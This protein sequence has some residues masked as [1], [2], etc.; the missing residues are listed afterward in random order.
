SKTEAVAAGLPADSYLAVEDIH[1]NFG[2]VKAI[3]GVGFQMGRGMISSIIGPNGAGKSSMLNVISGFYQPSRGRIFFEGKD[4]TRLPAHAV[5]R[6]RFC[7]PLPD[8]A[9]ARLGFARTF[10]NIA[11]FKGMTTL[12]NIMTGRSL[13]IRGNFLTDALYWGFAQK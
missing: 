3:T 8:T 13:R 2:G 4:R 11:L 12:D 5:A 7:G 10:Q 1:L 9:A 6:L